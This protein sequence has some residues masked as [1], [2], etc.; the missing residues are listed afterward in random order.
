MTLATHPV[1]HKVSIHNE[2][3]S[4]CVSNHN[5]IA[6][7]FNVVRL[8]IPGY[9][10]EVHVYQTRNHFAHGKLSER[11]YT[12]LN[13]VKPRWHV[14]TGL[15]SSSSVIGKLISSDLSSWDDLIKQTPGP[16]KFRTLLLTNLVAVSDNFVFLFIVKPTNKSILRQ[17]HTL[18]TQWITILETHRKAIYLPF[19]TCEIQKL[20]FSDCFIACADDSLHELHCNARCI[21]GC[22]NPRPKHYNQNHKQETWPYLNHLLTHH[23]KVAECKATMFDSK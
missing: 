11:L 10:N 9:L 17:S 20:L 12:E 8:I 14:K 6:Q 15:K 16:S 5:F 21:A 4:T 23:V 7:W 2:I 18:Q 3:K 1:S 13:S 22:G 19:C